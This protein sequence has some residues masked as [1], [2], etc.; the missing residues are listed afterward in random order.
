MSRWE[1]GLVLVLTCITIATLAFV[2][3]PRLPQGEEQLAA[4]LGLD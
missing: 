2:P 3:P 1:W 4:L